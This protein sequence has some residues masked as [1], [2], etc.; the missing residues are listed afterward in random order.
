MRAFITASLFATFRPA[1]SHYVFAHLIVNDTLFPEWQY[2]RKFDPVVK[3]ES[4]G[5]GLFGPYVDPLYNFTTPDLRCGRG[6]FHNG[7]DTEVA[8]VL[9][10]T[11]VG[12]QVGLPSYESDQKVEVVGHTGPGSAWLSKAEGTLEAYQGDG[13]WVKIAQIV[14]RDAEERKSFPASRKEFDWAL[15]AQHSW[16]FTIPATTPPGEYVLRIEHLYP[17]PPSPTSILNK[18]TQWYVSC[19]HIRILGDGGAEFEPTVRIPGLYVE[20]QRDVFF[21]SRTADFNLS[22]YT[23]P[24]P[25]VWAG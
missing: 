7:A 20:G 4:A 5:E 1:T 23:P 11:Q 21:D 3:N 13:E 8:T 15:Y 17:T 22:A 24:P 10:G 2:I 9:A 12:F 16:N 14:A 25:L 18:G 6:A 19:A